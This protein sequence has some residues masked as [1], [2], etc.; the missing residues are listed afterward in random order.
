[1]RKSVRRAGAIA[2]IAL[3]VMLAARTVAADPIYDADVNAQVV[4]TFVGAW[5]V[6]DGPVWTSNPAVLNALETAALLFGGA[7]TDYAISTVSNN[8]ADIN[9]MS[10]VDGWGD[11]TFL[12]NP[13][14]ENFKVDLGN[15]GYNDP[16]GTD[17]AFSA[18]VLD[19]SC[20]NRYGN[21]NEPCGPNEPGLNY[22]FRIEAVPEPATLTLFGT[23]V[24]GLVARRRRA[25]N[26]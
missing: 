18:Y 11:S 3:G 7:P 23:G 2:G 12:T 17:T 15:P 16:G 14:A 25:R 22:A 4:A 19:H 21:P 13:V 9:F 24:I 5:H 6:G 8:P 20:G 1:M 26:N 10:F